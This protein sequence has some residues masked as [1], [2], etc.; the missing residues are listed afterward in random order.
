M[1][2]KDGDRGMRRQ[3][4]IDREKETRLQRIKKLF[5]NINMSIHLLLIWILLL[6]QAP[7]VGS[8]KEMLRYIDWNYSLIWD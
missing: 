6:T 4:C 7:W 5:S 1:G 2:G 8:K 3:M